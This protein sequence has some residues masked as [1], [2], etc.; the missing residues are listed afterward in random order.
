MT[1]KIFS[2]I[3][4][5][6]G[7]VIGLGAFAHG[8][9]TQQVHQALDRFPIDPHV[10]ATI[11]VVWYFVS[12]CMLLFGITIVW[13]WFRLRAGQTGLLFV[14]ALIGLLYLATGVAGYI[15]LHGDPFMLFF[16]AL[17]LLLLISSYALRHVPGR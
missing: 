11:Y 15:Y 5:I 13:I 6:V 16:A 2:F 4:L 1:Y 17:G 8:L 10:G 3:F 12:G 14:A 9:A 7:I